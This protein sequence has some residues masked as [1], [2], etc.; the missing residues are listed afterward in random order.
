MLKHLTDD[1]L[2]QFVV[3]KLN[4]EKGIAEHVRLCEGCK[5]KVEVYKLLITGIKRQPQPVFDFDLSAAVVQQ[6]PSAKIKEASDR[7]LIWLFVFIGIGLAGIA[8]YFFHD[9]FAY[10]FEGV[11]AILIYLIIITAVVTLTGLF[12]DMYNKY[13]REMKILDSY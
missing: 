9:S 1:E 8:I 6:L 13:K 11:K 2:Q 7:L 5:A 3:D 12:I 4:C 10:L